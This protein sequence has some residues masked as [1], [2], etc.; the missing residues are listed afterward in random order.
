M[1]D[2]NLL[3][4][5]DIITTMSMA[6][7][8]IFSLI[9]YIQKRYIH[10][11]Y[12]GIIWIVITIANIFYTASEI[13]FNYVFLIIQVNLISVQLLFSIGFFDFISR[14]APDIKK[15]I[16][17]CFLGGVLLYNSIDSNDY[18]INQVSGGLRLMSYSHN[19]SIS[20]G[21]YISL[22]GMLLIVLVLYIWYQS[23]R[24]LRSQVLITLIGTVILILRGIFYYPIDALAPWLNLILFIIGGTFQ[25]YAFIRIPQVAFVLANKV[26]MII[27]IDTQSGLPVFEYNWT[28]NLE[29]FYPEIAKTS[30]TMFGINVILKDLLQG[31]NIHEIHLDRGT[32]LIQ[33]SPDEKWLFALMVIKPIKQIR[34]V[35]QHFCHQFSHSFSQIS[36][37]EYGD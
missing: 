33:H 4:I 7:V 20:N 27:V 34:G 35:L 22:L 18:S 8:A 9:R 14:D 10:L 3:A 28:K 31:G 2:L 26:I 36:V 12:L 37:C 25:I 29:D 24:N 21:L 17:G 11:L 5:Y 6:F 13:T 16:I 23:P 32:M 30:G 19:Y 15:Y 1:M